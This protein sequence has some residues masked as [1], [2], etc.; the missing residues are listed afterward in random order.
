[1][2]PIVMQN[3]Q[4]ERFQTHL[5][6]NTIKPRRINRHLKVGWRQKNLRGR[7]N[8]KKKGRGGANCHNNL[9]WK[10]RGVSV[11]EFMLSVHMCLWWCVNV[12]VWWGKSSYGFLLTHKKGGSEVE[13]TG[14]LHSVSPPKYRCVSAGL[15]PPAGASACSGWGQ[16]RHDEARVDLLSPSP[17][18]LEDDPA[19][20]L[21]KPHSR[22][23]DQYVPPGRNWSDLTD[24][25]KMLLNLK[26]N[27]KRNT[28]Y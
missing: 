28:V 4:T 2:A 9:V 16:R 1:M 11:H 24:L 10:I 19:G 26:H 12:C 7:Q 21:G 6:D 22:R 27:I 5:A 13:R 8:K 23:A 20:R 25:Q 17:G 14:T 15:R 3:V 18:G